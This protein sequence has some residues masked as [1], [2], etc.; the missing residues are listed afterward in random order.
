MEAMHKNSRDEKNS[1]KIEE[2]LKDTEDKLTDTKKMLDEIRTYLSERANTG[3]KKTADLLKKLNDAVAEGEKAGRDNAF[4][5]ISAG[6]TDPVNFILRLSQDLEPDKSYSSLNDVYHELQQLENK[7]SLPQSLKTPVHIARS[8]HLAKDIGEQEQTFIGQ[9]DHAIG[10][11]DIKKVVAWAT[12]AQLLKKY[13]LEPAAEEGSVRPDKATKIVQNA[14]DALNKLNASQGQPQGGAPGTPGEAKK[15]G[16]A[17]QGQQPAP[18]TTTASGTSGAPGTPGEAPGNKV[19]VK[20]EGEAPGK[21]KNETPESLEAV[22][23][24]KKGVGSELVAEMSKR[25]NYIKKKFITSIKEPD[26]DSFQKAN[27]AI[28]QFSA[29][30]L[31]ILNKVDLSKEQR[32]KLQALQNDLNEAVKEKA[33]ELNIGTQTQTVSEKHL[34]V[35]EKHIENLM[36]IKEEEY[37]KV[38]EQAITDYHNQVIEIFEELGIPKEN[39]DETLKQRIKRHRELGKL[40]RKISN[41]ESQNL[42]LPPTI[43]FTNWQ[44]STDTPK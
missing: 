42:N 12:G 17:P 34:K 5:Q 29:E 13:V 16:E 18:G 24:A 30:L 14:E 11:D 6:K 40:L 7:S 3:D 33:K 43:V 36:K 4:K 15:E 20:K 10:N 39:I 44:T 23:Y 37:E 21:A 38:I 25:E 1:T 32:E 8:M 31:A 19:G 28:L 9:I 22:T 26:T 2:K 27:A 41:E 35:T